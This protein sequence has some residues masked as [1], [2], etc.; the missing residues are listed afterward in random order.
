[1]ETAPPISA[2]KFSTK[3]LNVIWEFPGWN[4][5]LW[6][7]QHV[8]C[9]H[10]KACCAWGGYLSLISRE[11]LNLRIGL[12][13]REGVKGLNSSSENNWAKQ[14]YSIY[15]RRGWAGGNVSN[16]QGRKEWDLRLRNTFQ[17]HLKKGQHKNRWKPPTFWFILW[18]PPKVALFSPSFCLI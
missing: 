17:P 3:T 15:C 16:F 5:F 8:R 1:M 10:R 12:I 6:K 18:Y 9:L 7:Q 13:G 4:V 2:R 11:F 14:E